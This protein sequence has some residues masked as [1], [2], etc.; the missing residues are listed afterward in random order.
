[1][2]TWQPAEARER[3]RRSPDARR[4]S[5]LALDAADQLA[6]LLLME[7]QL[8]RARRIVVELIALLVRSDVKI[9]QEHFAIPYC[10]VSVAQ[11]SLALPE[12]FYFCPAQHNAGLPRLENVVVVSRSFVPGHR[13]G[14]WS[15]GGACHPNSQ[16]KNRR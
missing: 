12:R 14:R 8:S 16:L 13:G 2:A 11:V 4:A 3:L 5:H 10:R 6:N 9:Q 15:F 7:Q 1:M